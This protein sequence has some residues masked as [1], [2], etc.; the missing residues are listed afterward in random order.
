[1]DGNTTTTEEEEL[2][3][4]VGSEMPDVLKE[5]GNTFSQLDKIDFMVEE[6]KGK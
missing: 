5:I 6:V 2:V 1:M 4:A 3:A